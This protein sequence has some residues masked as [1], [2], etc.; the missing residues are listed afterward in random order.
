MHRLNYKL[1]PGLET[2]YAIR[3][4]TW[5]R[6]TLQL[7]GPTVHGNTI[8][9]NDKEELTGLE[10]YLVISTSPLAHS[11]RIS[12]ILCQTFCTLHHRR[13]G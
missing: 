12:W 13:N 8:H 1:K 4:E 5:I 10:C 2:C 9:E 6:P 7:L 11:S 3:P